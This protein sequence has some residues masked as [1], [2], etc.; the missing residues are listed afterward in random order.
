MVGVPGRSKACHTCKRRKRGVSASF[1]VYH[2][3]IVTRH[4]LNNDIKTLPEHWL[5]VS[6][7]VVVRSTATLVWAVSAFRSPMRR[8]WQDPHLHQQHPRARWHQYRPFHT[9]VILCAPNK[10][11]SHAKSTLADSFSSWHYFFIDAYS[12]SPP[13][14]YRAFSI[15]V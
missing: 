7:S 14:I 8:L 13:K 11:I 1:N 10:S 15:G 2:G 4:A 9:P 5:S 6:F 12:F 3:P